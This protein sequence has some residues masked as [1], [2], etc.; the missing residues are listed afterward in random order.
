MWSPRE[1]L[2]RGLG[3]QPPTPTMLLKLFKFVLPFG[4]HT[5]LCHLLI[6]F[7]IQNEFNAVT[8]CQ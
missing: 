1:D 6:L 8:K 5:I 7:Q 3:W 4:K 2:E